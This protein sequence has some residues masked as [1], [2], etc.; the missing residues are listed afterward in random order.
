MYASW[1]RGNFTVPYVNL[2]LKI[3]LIKKTKRL[4]KIESFKTDAE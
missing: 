2:S 4:I 1:I 3:N